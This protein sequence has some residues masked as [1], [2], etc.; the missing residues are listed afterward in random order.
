MTLYDFQGL[1]IS[2]ASTTS[3]TSTASFH[4]KITDPDHH[5]VCNIDRF[6]N[7]VTRDQWSNG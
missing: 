2:A 1:R 3:M 7:F 6:A 4:Q 5:N